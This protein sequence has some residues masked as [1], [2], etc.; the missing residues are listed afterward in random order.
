MHFTHSAKYPKFHLQKTLKIIN[1]VGQ[2]KKET[3]KRRR[4][5][6]KQVIAMTFNGFSVNDKV[7]FAVTAK[8]KELFIR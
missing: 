5:K 8:T 7:A 1:E 4:M 6:D 3:L 2:K